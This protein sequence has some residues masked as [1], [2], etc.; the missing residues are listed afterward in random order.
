EGD[1]EHTLA[2]AIRRGAQERGLALPPVRDFEALKGR[3][4]RGQWQGRPL[5]VG[6]PRLLESLG[7]QLPE[8]LAAFEREASGKGQSVV[9]LV[10]ERQAVASLALADEVRPESRE[11]VRQLHALK[12][13][14]AMLT[15]DSRAVAQA[16]AAELGIDT[17]FAEVLPEDKDKK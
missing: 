7:V 5:H 10:V 6:G 9:H 13:Q 12:L 2:R 8:R 3:G 14:V 17:F 11:A 16:V 1:S 15:G 4:L